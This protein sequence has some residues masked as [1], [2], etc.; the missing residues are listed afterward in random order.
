MSQ[1]SDSPTDHTAKLHSDRLQAVLAKARAIRGQSSPQPFAAQPWVSAAAAKP[2]YAAKHATTR[3]NTNALANRGAT[4]APQQASKSAMHHQH[5]PQKPVKLGLAHG[6]VQQQQ[7]QQ[8]TES[9]Q[10]SMHV[11]QEGRQATSVATSQP[12]QAPLQ[13]P[14]SFR[15]ALA[16][17]RFAIANQS[18]PVL[19]TSLLAKAQTH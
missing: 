15:K 19:H 10:R 18:L 8:Q 7:Q 6:K 4:S 11:Q 14:A 9:K 13:L 12:V 3:R 17:F 1:Q 2:S 5:L 16:A